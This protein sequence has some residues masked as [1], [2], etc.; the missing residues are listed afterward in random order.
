[1]SER[2]RTSKTVSK[3]TQKRGD[4]I[5][6]LAFSQVELERSEM[7]K[8]ETP[9]PGSP[10]PE[11]VESPMRQVSRV[12]VKLG[13]AC[14]NRCTFCHATGNE[15]NPPLRGADV[16]DRL[17][18]ARLMGANMIVFSGG[19][20]TLREELPNFARVADKL[21]MRSGVVSNGR[22]LSYTKLVDAL[23]D[24]GLRYAY[25][26]LHGSDAA[27]HDRV[28]GVPGAHAQA[29]QGIRNLLLKPEIEVTVNCVVIQD[30]LPHLGG[31]PAVLRAASLAAA[32]GEPR[33]YRLKFSF[34]EPKGRAEADF[35][36]VVPSLAGAAA[37]A[38]EAMASA[39]DEMPEG[40]PEPAYDGFPPCVMGGRFDLMD[41]LFTHQIYHM[42]EAFEAE[43]YPCDNGA[44]VKPAP[45]AS[46]SQEA[47][48]PGVYEGYVAR[49]GAAEL[50]PLAPN[51]EKDASPA[52][53]RLSEAE[54]E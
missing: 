45:C 36:R 16:V 43:F 52:K 15:V 9:S 34:V 19:E 11:Y 3:G 13:Y 1:M 10:P 41:D 44:R 7:S 8:I 33:P 2:N 21:G 28:V 42:S 31:I 22:I 5:W 26:S 18:A 4:V 29:V 37:R 46:C 14:N 23:Y 32:Q 6:D 50:R 49:R 35:E 48:C 30:T 12:L 47:K 38:L 53:I 51:L 20:P 40:S 27:T 39:R 54:G 24:A 17:R 25:I